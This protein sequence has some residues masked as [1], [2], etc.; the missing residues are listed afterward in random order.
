MTRIARIGTAAE[1]DVTPEGV[2]VVE[3]RGVVTIGAADEVKRRIY[4]ALPVVPVGV[5]SDYRQAVVAMTPKELARIMIGARH[6]LP[7]LPAAV[8]AN[9]GNCRQLY[10]A[11]VT[12]AACGRW[13][14]VCRDASQALRWTLRVADETPEAQCSGLGH[15]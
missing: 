4:D 8:V 1:F 11:S 9:D 15:L 10:W 6:D 7:K 13:R 2:L 3:W 5:V 12:A 14:H